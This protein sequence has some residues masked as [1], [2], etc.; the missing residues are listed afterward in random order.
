MKIS[1][2]KKKNRQNGVKKKEEWGK[3]QNSKYERNGAEKGRKK[4]GEVG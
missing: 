3:K 4:V 1:E 2:K